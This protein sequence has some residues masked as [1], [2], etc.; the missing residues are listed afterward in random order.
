MFP[1]KDF[2]FLCEQ[3]GNEGGFLGN[4]L[5]LTVWGSN[6]SS[7]GWS[8]LE[9]SMTAALFHLAV[10]FAVQKEDKMQGM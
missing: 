5:S 7:D 2:A 1:A 4:S 3:L 10:I 8:I 9:S 6:Q